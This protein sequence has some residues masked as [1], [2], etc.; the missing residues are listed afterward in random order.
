MAVKN[1]VLI[2]GNG[3]RE[4]A[5]GWAFL[6]DPRIEKIWF[7]GAMGRMVS[8]GASW[9]LVGTTLS[10]EVP[11]GG[12]AWNAGGDAARRCASAGRK[13]PLRGCWGARG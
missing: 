10:G 8:G 1:T 13:V 5:L 11:W 2:V 4:H 9:I 3:G 7:A 6:Q 12:S